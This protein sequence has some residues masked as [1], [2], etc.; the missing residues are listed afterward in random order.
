MLDTDP[1][2]EQFKKG[3][4]WFEAVVSFKRGLLHFQ[5]NHLIVKIDQME[6]RGGPI[7]HRKT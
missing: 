1:R 2:T 4:V 5:V 3:K 7:F 6:E